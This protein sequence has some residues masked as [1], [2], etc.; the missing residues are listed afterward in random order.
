MPVPPC[1]RYREPLRPSRRW[2][3]SLPT[4]RP[5]SDTGRTSQSPTARSSNRS[6]GARSGTQMSSESGD[7]RVRSKITWLYRQ[8]GHPLIRLARLGA[9]EAMRPLSSTLDE[10]CHLTMGRDLS[11]G[12]GQPCD[13][14]QLL[15]LPGD[16]GPTAGRGRRGRETSIHTAWPGPLFTP[17]FLTRHGSQPQAICLQQC[18][19][20]IRHADG[21]INIATRHTLG[22]LCT[23]LIEGEGNRCRQPGDHYGPGSSCFT[24]SRRVTSPTLTVSL[25]TS[26]RGYTGPRCAMMASNQTAATP[27]ATQQ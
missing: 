16:G 4:R 12:R 18:L 23:Q 21:R 26:R 20:S 17:D 11:S 1:G 14:L 25:T 19:H 7:R 27:S 6:A 15:S 22:W 8:R 2:L 5:R 10:I 13:Q 9:E 24:P 3:N